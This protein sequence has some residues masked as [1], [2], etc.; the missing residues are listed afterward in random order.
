MA[1]CKFPLLA[2]ATILTTCLS[3]LLLLLLLLIVVPPNVVKSEARRSSN[4]RQPPQSWRADARSHAAAYDD[5]EFPRLRISEYEVVDESGPRSR[6]KRAANFLNVPNLFLNY[7]QQDNVARSQQQQQTTTTTRRSNTPNSKLQDTQQQTSTTTRNGGE[8]LLVCPEGWHQHS[9]QCYKFFHQRHSW[10]RARDVCERHGAQLALIYDYQQNNFTTQLAS[11]AFGSS[12]GGVPGGST[13]G[14]GAGA[15]GPA[16]AVLDSFQR[17]LNDFKAGQVYASDER[18][19]WIG[20]RAIDRLE[21]NTLE[22]AA[23]TFVSKY[24]GFWD[25]DEP[26]VSAGECVRATVRHESGPMSSFASSYKLLLQSSPGQQQSGLAPGPNQQ[27]VWQLA[28]CED[29]LPF[30]CQRQVCSSNSFHCSN[31]RCINAAWKCD[32]HNDC[33]DDSD[34][35]DCPRRCRFY[36]SSSGDKVQSINYPQRYEPNS[37]CKWTLEGPLGTGMMLQFYEFDTEKNYDQ[38]QVLAG[39]RTEDKAASLATL[40]GQLNLTNQRPFITGSNLMIVKFK[41]DSLVERR[42]FRASWKS[43]PI[44][45]GAGSE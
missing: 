36:M 20:F 21:T 44:E 22:S 45:C 16:S 40:S 13:G 28:K 1:K 33:G 39:A 29:L 6:A 35:M 14:G 17:S 8:S 9:T 31:G 41:S 43:E 3:V 7:Q 12:S 38:V 23:N 32:G 4:L 10:Q 27:Q 11:Q 37:D 19:Y 26:R 24:L 15:A 25:Y 18:S 34:E 30:A 5:E 42:G 2:T